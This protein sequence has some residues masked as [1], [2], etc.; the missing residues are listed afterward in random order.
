M[1]LLFKFHWKYS[2]PNFLFSI[3]TPKQGRTK[4]PI[5]QEEI[6]YTIS[7]NQKFHVGYHTM[8]GIAKRDPAAPKS[9][10]TWRC[11]L[12]YEEYDLYQYLK[13]YIVQLMKI[14]S[15]DMLLDM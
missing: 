1:L 8:V 2:F 14:T 7:Y 3:E 4:I 11:L 5:T 15:T 9:L 10:I 12:I 6:D 13:M